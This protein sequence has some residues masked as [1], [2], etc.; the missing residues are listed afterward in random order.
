MCSRFYPRAGLPCAWPLQFNYL[1]HFT[2][3]MKD[4]RYRLAKLDEH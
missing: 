3:L 1:G 2:D 4:V